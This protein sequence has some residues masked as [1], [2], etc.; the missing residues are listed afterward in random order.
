MRTGKVFY[1]D[2]YA[3]LLKQVGDQYSFTYDSEY[4]KDGVPISIS[5]P[6]QASPLVD[7]DLHPFFENL[8]SEGWMRKLQSQQQ[9]IDEQDPF[10]L[11]LAN[12]RD[13]I[14]S[15]TVLPGE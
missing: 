12:G 9:S 13:L 5:L 10:G 2:R 11:L 14:G 1:K 6:L 8:V 15:V 4:L 3:G 7:S